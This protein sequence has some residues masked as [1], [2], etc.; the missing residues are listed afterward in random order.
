MLTKSTLGP[1]QL[2]LFIHDF[3]S[4]HVQNDIQIEKSY[5]KYLF[6]KN[7]EKIKV[8]YTRT[9]DASTIRMTLRIVH[10][11]ALE[12]SPVLLVHLGTFVAGLSMLLPASTVTMTARANRLR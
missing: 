4:C 7:Q 11:P 12:V 9:H 6:R 2:F 10:R 8:T 5:L 1:P 3:E